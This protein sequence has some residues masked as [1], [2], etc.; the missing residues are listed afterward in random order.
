[1]VGSAL[2]AAS[3]CSRTPCTPRT[4][5]VR[6]S[7]GG[8]RPDAPPCEFQVHV[9]VPTCGGHR[10]PGAGHPPAGRGIFAVVEGIRRP[11]EPR[12]VPPTSRSCS[13]RSRPGVA[14]RHPGARLRRANFNMRA[15]F[16]EGGATTPGS[17][18]VIVAAVGD[19]HHGFQQVDTVAALFIAAPSTCCGRRHDHARDPRRCSWKSTP[20]GLDLDLFRQH[21]MGLHHV[22]ARARRPRL[23]GRHWACPTISAHAVVE[24]E[25]F[26]MATPPPA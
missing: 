18:G 3:P 21:I 20:P 26:R 11:P 23:H 12:V 5:S 22:V 16:L 19:R 7:P 4:P 9:G 13:V 10:R 25:C 14:C 8:G 24:D 6:R 17:L 1:M 15:A 2:T